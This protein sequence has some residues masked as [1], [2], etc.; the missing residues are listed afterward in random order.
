MKLQVD[1]EFHDMDNLLNN[2]MQEQKGFPC[3]KVLRISRQSYIP[4]FTNWITQ[5]SY[6]N[7]LFDKNQ[8]ARVYYY[9]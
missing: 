5:S 9:L 3:E 8:P 6:V 7:E 4:F 1:I 2:I